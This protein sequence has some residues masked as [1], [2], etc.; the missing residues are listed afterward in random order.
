VNG[1][2]VQPIVKQLH[3]ACGIIEYRGLVLTAQRNELMSM[4]LK[5]EFP[6]GKIL[7]N[8]TP[9]ECLQRELLEELGVL[10]HINRT[11]PVSDH[12]YST[13]RVSL[14]PFVC[15]I[16][17]GTFAINEHAALAWLLP[18]QLRNLDWSEADIPVVNVYK[19]QCAR[20]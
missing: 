14:Y 6:G 19:A 2:L 15:E 18:D 16:A 13:L 8:E 11:L 10:V 3:V 4:P 5:W 9:E 1:F 7:P 12:D 20:K 17:S